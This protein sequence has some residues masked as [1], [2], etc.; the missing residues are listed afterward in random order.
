MSVFDKSKVI[1]FD[2]PVKL[3]KDE[4]E[5]RHWLEMNKEWW[6]K[7]PMRY[8]WRK[9]I[10]FAEFSKEFY[11]EVDKRFFASHRATI[12][13]MKLPFDGIIDFE[14]L[15]E[16]NVLEIGVG[17]GTHAQLLAGFSGSFV[18]L[19]LTDYAVKSTSR[20]MEV[21][22]IKNATILQMNAEDLQFE[23]HTFDFVWSW[24]VIH[25][26]ANTKKILSEI[27]KVLKP[28]GKFTCMV[29]HRGYWN[30]HVC[31]FL[32]G[33]FKGG[34]RKGIHRVVQNNTDGAIARFYS[35]KEWRKDLE[36]KGFKVN[37][38]RIMGLKPEIL[39]LPGGK[40][41]KVLLALVP[42]GV[43]R[44]LTTKLRM[45]S[46]VVSDVTRD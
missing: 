27:H 43:S 15:K 34:L 13:F 21:F 6:E 28:G 1:D 12:P 22:G 16:K 19:D 38:I 26:S 42:D 45:G 24:G 23:P 7:N 17:N 30:Y 5:R 2:R 44:F 3:P 39:P 41:K 25:H 46:F 11:Q 4:K 33:L 9:E 10:G 35:I 31:G 18:G 29:Y 32:A 37:S 40:I 36:E 8:D 14:S 20:R